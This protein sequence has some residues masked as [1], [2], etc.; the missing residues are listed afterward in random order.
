M[1][2]DTRVLSHVSGLTDANGVT[3]HGVELDH[4]IRTR[5]NGDGR[6]FSI[7]EGPWQAGD[8]KDQHATEIAAREAV[9]QRWLDAAGE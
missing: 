7:D 4:R 2:D 1:N 8:W 6:A 9:R 3:D 5:K